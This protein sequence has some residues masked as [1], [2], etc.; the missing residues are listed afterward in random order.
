MKKPF[1]FIALLC[2]AGTAVYGAPVLAAPGNPAPTAAPASMLTPGT[3]VHDSAGEV[4]GTIV[5]VEG[6]RVAVA[7]GN[8]GIVVPA[9]AFVQT[10]KG[11]ALNVT[12]AELVAS[13][14]QAAQKN[15]AALDKEL[16]VGANVSSAGG[17]S[18]LGQVKAVNADAAV[19]A[20]GKG[21]VTLPRSMLFATKT[22]L[23][24]NLS[25]K[26]FAAAVAKAKGAAP[27]Q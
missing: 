11:P 22:G 27:G 14:Q 12:K 20:T 21:D 24:A 10:G 25:G 5:Q 6:G 1:G 3:K 2:L 15:A 16:K 13:V 8:N 7:V 23:A 9:N 17:N 4:V 18:V 19:L 26:Q